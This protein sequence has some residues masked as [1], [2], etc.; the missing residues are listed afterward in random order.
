MGTRWSLG[1]VFDTEMKISS[2]RWQVYA[3]RALFV[4]ALLVGM[5]SI[6]WSYLD[7]KW[8]V[9]IQNQAKIGEAYFYAMVGVQLAL[10]MIVAPAATAGA[11]CVE[12]SR[13]SL[14]HMLVTD[15]TAREII[16]GKLLA[17]LLPSSPWSPA[18]GRSRHWERFLEG[19]IR[20][21]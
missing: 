8:S 20:T 16:L 17:R 1:P 19:S 18:R 3:G 6:W 2:R 4:T 14:A 5:G 11:V 13:G 10:T 12:R 15:L 21:T 9:G 7:D